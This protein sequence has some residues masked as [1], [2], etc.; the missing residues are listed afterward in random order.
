M[1]YKNAYRGIEKIHIAE[2][3]LII[4][5]FLLSMI[6][7]LFSTIDFD[8]LIEDTGTALGIIIVII[9]VIGMILTI[10]ADIYNIWGLKIA[11][12]DDSMFYIPFFLS[13]LIIIADTVI[14]I[15]LFITDKS[16]INLVIDRAEEI[17][18][19]VQMVVV[20]VVSSKLAK[21]LNGTSHIKKSRVVLWI[22]IVNVVFSFGLGASSLLTDAHNKVLYGISEAL[23]IISF[24]VYLI[25]VDMTIKFLKKN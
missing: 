2:I 8:K 20:V 23:E 11:S 17:V 15:I 5:T 9:V 21:T 14:G 4:G 7:A 25:Y 10:A 22:I 3:M 24:I 19:L 13:I 18:E 1:T 12:L 16:V 6:Q